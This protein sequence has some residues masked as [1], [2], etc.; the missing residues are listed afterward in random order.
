MKRRERNYM[1]IK[2]RLKR[3]N[4]GY[5]TGVLSMWIVILKLKN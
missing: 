4:R 2:V 5:K 3:N 1:E